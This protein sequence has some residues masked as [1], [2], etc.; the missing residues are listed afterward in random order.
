[1]TKQYIAS[2]KNNTRGSWV[3]SVAPHK[4]TTKFWL[5]P[6]ITHSYSDTLL[7]EE[8]LIF[9]DE[10][11]AESVLK[12]LNL[13]YP[14]TFTLVIE[15]EDVFMSEADFPTVCVKPEQFR[16]LL[17]QQIN[18]FIRI[19]KN[20]TGLE[21]QQ[22]SYFVRGQIKMTTCLIDDEWKKYK[23]TGR[24]Y[25]EFLFYL[26]IKYELLGVY[27]INELKAGE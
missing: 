11:K 18:E 5:K 12:T 2:I 21:Y 4:N 20:E 26:V 10:Q 13:I 3:S 7:K 23:E 22:K 24:S 6:K 25:Y 15:K 19:E 27:R 9:R 8:R 1:M 16:E 14:D 17:T